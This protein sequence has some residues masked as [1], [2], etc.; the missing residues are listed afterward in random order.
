VGL[1]V[2][3]PPGLT[4]WDFS[5][6]FN[7]MF[8]AR[9]RRKEPLLLEKPNT[10]PVPA[11]D[12]LCFRRFLG[13]RHFTQGPRLSDTTGNTL[14]PAHSDGNAADHHDTPYDSERSFGGR[15]FSVCAERGNG[16]VEESFGRR[17]CDLIPEMADFFAFFT[18]LSEGIYADLKMN[19][20]PIAGD[21]GVA[22]RRFDS[23][24]SERLVGDQQ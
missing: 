15:Y 12:V 11:G 18:N 17:T 5:P 16:F 10:A 14:I 1:P 19:L 7:T 21:L 22:F 8:N 4:F 23:L 20:R 24:G 13:G 6:V 9:P 3:K 2:V